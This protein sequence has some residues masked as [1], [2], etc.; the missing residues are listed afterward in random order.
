MEW[1]WGE[2][3]R[4]FQ[5][6]PTLGLNKLRASTIDCTSKYI[7]GSYAVA[8]FGEGAF[9]KKREPAE[10]FRQERYSWR[11][12][13]YSSKRK[14]TERENVSG[15]G[16]WNPWEEFMRNYGQSGGFA[17]DEWANKRRRRE[18]QQREQPRYTEALRVDQHYAVLGVSSTASFDEI[19][20][21]YRRKAREN[22]P[23]L[24]PNEKEKYTARMAD[25]NAAFEAI[26]KRFKT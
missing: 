2:S 24:H 10:N 19:K 20:Q 11:Q 22:H 5:Y 9:W 23:D 25:I 1:K 18:R 3:P 26:S 14:E 6:G 12:Y 13:R 8:D 17:Y 15:D 21:A 7:T 16:E 4:A